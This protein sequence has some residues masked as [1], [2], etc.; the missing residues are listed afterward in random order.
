MKIAIATD[1]A[2]VALRK[3]IILVLEE[4]GHQVADLGPAE[5]ESVDY[6]DYAVKVA[7]RVAEQ[8][9][10]FGILLCGTGIGMSIAANKIKTIRAALC[11]SEETARL[12]REHNDANVL[13]LGARI[14]DEA[15][16]NACVKIFL[17][18]AF[19]G[20]RHEKRVQKISELERA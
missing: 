14:L 17:A 6:P 11:H 9:A 8:E 20:G 16:V 1:H 13:C 15:T 2:A 5:G 12:A 10:D 19:E 3:K 4:G 7:R 18:T